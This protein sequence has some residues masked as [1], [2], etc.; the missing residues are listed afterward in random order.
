V[1][2]VIIFERLNESELAC[3]VD[4]QFG[5]LTQRLA[6]QQLR[7]DVDKTAESFLTREGHDPQFGACPLKRAI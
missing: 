3:I 7:L 5:R 6:L 1:D 4:I 2:D